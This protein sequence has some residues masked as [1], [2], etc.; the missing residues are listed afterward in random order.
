M[1]P[2]LRI[3]FWRNGGT[4]IISVLMTALLACLHA[5]QA[6]PHVERIGYFQKDQRYA[7]RIDLLRLALENT[8]AEYGDY[9][10]IPVAG[11][12]TQARGEAF[13]AHPGS[14][15][16]VAFLPTTV[17]REKHFLPVRIPILRGILG[18]R[19]LLIHARNTEKFAEVQTLD[20][21]RQHFR[22]GF[23]TDWA[24]LKIL[25]HNGLPVVDTPSYESLFR[26]LHAGRFDYFPR[27]LNEAWRELEVWRPELKALQVEERLA[28]YYP[29][30]VYYFVNRAD[31]Q[32]AQRIEMG[33][34]RALEDGS[35]EKLFRKYHED[36][37][38][39]ARIGERRLLR[40][41][42]PNLP[43]DTPALG[44][45]WWLPK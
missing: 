37:I 1:T 5:A 42:N 18:Y 10:L 17:E 45:G 20:Q 13:L 14:P 6:A 41:E 40:L 31:T 23:G 39:R 11:E 38:R 19:V 30:P 22:A 3:A 24:D 43:A 21:L 29:Y 2:L 15:V 16:R 44:T 33:L 8:R 32:L 36:D 27:G 12:M 7:Y 34:R 28:L 9:A 25:R 26:M 35:F 4:T